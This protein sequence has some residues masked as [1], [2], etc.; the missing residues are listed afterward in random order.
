MHDHLVHIKIPVLSESTSK[1]NIPDFLR[2]PK[3]FLVERMI[4]CTRD[5][6]IGVATIVRVFVT[7]CGMGMLL[8]I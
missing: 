3:V 1:I 8:K 5:G 6:I 2:L 4:F 7:N